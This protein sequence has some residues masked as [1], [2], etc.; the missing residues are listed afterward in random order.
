[1]S[2]CAGEVIDEILVSDDGRVCLFG[3]RIGEMNVLS[4]DVS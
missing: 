1:M 3:K 4:N 2:G